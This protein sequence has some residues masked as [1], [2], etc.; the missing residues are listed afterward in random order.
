MNDLLEYV[1][2]TA[3]ATAIRESGWLFPI[4]ETV[5]VLGLSLVV[6]S[7]FMI[8]LRLLYVSSAKQRPVTEMIREVLPWTWGS[9]AVATVSGF[10]LFVSNGPDYWRLWTLRAKAALLLAAGLNMLVFHLGAY[11]TVH[12]WDTAPG[13]PGAAKMAGGLSLFFWVA[14]VVCGR[15][16]GFL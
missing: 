9:F 14:I 15:W 13:T 6:G 1:Y 10:L 3:L 11:R 12:E 5:H 16:I 7:I 2:D 8:D 4:V